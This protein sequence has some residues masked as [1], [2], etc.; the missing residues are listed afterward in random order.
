MPIFKIKNKANF[1]SVPDSD[2]VVSFLTPTPVNGYVSAKEALSNSDIFSVTTLISGD[3]ASANLNTDSERLQ[4]FLQNPTKTSNAYSFWKSMFW[5]YILS[6]NA[7]AY[8]WRNKNGV[9]LY[10]EYLRPSQVSPFLLDDGSGLIYN[11]SFDEPE[12]GV[13][14]AVPQSDVIHFRLNSKNGGMT[15][16]GPLESLAN[17]LAIKD[18]SNRLTKTALGKAVVSPGVLTVKGG[19]L[20]NEKEKASRSRK[21][22]KQISSSGGGPIVLDDLETYTPLEIKADVAKLLSQADWT[23]NQVAKVFQIPDSYLNGQGDQQSSI[24]QIQGIYTNALNRYM[25][26]VISELNAKL[27]ARVRADV[28][29][30]IDPLQDELATKLSTMVKVGAIAPNQAQYILKQKGYLPDDLPDGVFPLK[31]GEQDEEDRN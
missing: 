10:W 12:I 15:G 13:I 6:G 17:E 20:L 3:L 27:N 25:A 11:I 5:Q 14:Q 9:D 7:Y 19:G 31:G 4:G 23:S 8:R 18:A 26:P 29:P 24:T 1:R 2:D 16:V 21:F 28:R 30:S 22:S